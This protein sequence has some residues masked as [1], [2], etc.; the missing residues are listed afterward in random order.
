[1]RSALLAFLVLACAPAGPVAI[2]TEHDACHWC[3]MT[4]SNPRFAAQ[5][6]V[7]GEEPQFFDDLGCL[8]SVRPHGE[9]YVADYDT[10]SWIAAERAH[11]ERCSAIDTPMGSHLIARA[12][13]TQNT[14]CIQVPAKEIIR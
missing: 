10:G 8:S 6:L 5:V 7:P 11:F 3:R 1:M 12:Q 2:D 13:P 9:I 14:G 4:I